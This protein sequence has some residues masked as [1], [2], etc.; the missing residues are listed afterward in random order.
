M[1]E[2]NWKEEIKKKNGQQ[3]QQHI[4]YD[5]VI[6]TEY[7]HSVATFLSLFILYAA[8][9]LCLPLKRSVDT[10][11][12]NLLFGHLIFF[13]FVFSPIFDG[14]RFCFHCVFFPPFFLFFIFYHGI[15]S[16]FLICY[17]FERVSGRFLYDNDDDDDL[18]DALDK[19]RCLISLNWRKKK[20]N[21]LRSY[22]HSFIQSS[23]I[24]IDFLGLVGSCMHHL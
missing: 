7:Y 2:S 15:V 5:D 3:Q 12:I 23:F 24:V 6:H 1:P 22:A 8:I 17:G 4:S 19:G 11:S 21:K 10:I 20:K 13:F 18:W 14:G 9:S 16:I